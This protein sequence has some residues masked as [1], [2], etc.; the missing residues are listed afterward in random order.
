MIKPIMIR[1]LRPRHKKIINTPHPI[2]QSNRLIKQVVLDIEAST[3]EPFI[4]KEQRPLFQ[5]PLVLRVAEGAH[6][7][8]EKNVAADQGVFQFQSVL[9][10]LLVAEAV[11]KKQVLV[12]GLEVVEGKAGGLAPS[13]S[14]EFPKAE[15]LASRLVDEKG[16]K[17]VGLGE[18]VEFWKEGVESVLYC[19]EGEEGLEPREAAG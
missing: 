19:G 13:K 16:D 1:E 12:L 10:E 8:F 9:L 6:V 5:S 15:V 4:P 17:R 18:A 14:R 11:D 7:V 3:A 2:P